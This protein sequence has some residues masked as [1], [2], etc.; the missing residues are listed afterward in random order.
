M[1]GANIV[2][3]VLCPM[4]LLFMPMVFLAAGGI[5]LVLDLLR[6]RTLTNDRIRAVKGE[7]WKKECMPLSAVLDGCFFSGGA[8][9]FTGLSPPPSPPFQT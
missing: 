9:P 8:L 3:Y 1:I 4:T 6:W 5:T 2:L 7:L